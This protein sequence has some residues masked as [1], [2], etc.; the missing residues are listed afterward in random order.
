MITSKTPLQELFDAAIKTLPDVES[1]EVFTVRDLF[2][3]FEWNRI[4]KGNRTKLGS[5]FY[6]YAQGTGA[7]QIKPLQKTPQNQQ[8]YKKL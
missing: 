5:M 1:D 8:L 3:G 6:A 4:E 7:S 2:R